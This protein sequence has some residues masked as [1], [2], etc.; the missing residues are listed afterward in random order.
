[1]SAGMAQVNVT[2]SGRTYRV[3]CDDGEE[4]HLAQLA[5]RLNRSI[6]QLR[7][8]F[9]EI[10]DHRLIVMAAITFADQQA[11]AERRLADLQAEIA[12]MEDAHTDLIDR[13]RRGQ[14]RVAE[15]IATLAERIEAIT[16]NA[17]GADG[18]TDAG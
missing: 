14:Q 15:T 10:G 13:H 8:R 5:E 3:A 1:M 4:D 6:E 17:A 12:G 7:A 11:E 2:I 9:G 18:E 16:A